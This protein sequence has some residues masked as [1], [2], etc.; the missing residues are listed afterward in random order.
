MKTFGKT[1]KLIAIISSAALLLCS[2]GEVST[3]GSA[4]ISQTNATTSNSIAT[5]TSA[6]STVQTSA[7]TENIG[8]IPSGFEPAAPNI[9]GG[10]EII[11][12]AL[13]MGKISVDGD[14]EERIMRAALVRRE[15]MLNDTMM[16]IDVLDDDGSVIASTMSGGYGFIAVSTAKNGGT[17]ILR[18]SF[19]ATGERFELRTFITEFSNI[20]TTNGTFNDKVSSLTHESMGMQGIG[21]EDGF[22]FYHDEITMFSNESAQLLERA[23]LGWDIVVLSDKQGSYAAMPGQGNT[24]TAETIAKIRGLDHAKVFAVMEEFL[25]DNK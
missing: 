4:G 2:C 3:T 23:G 5:S 20:N 1:K 24:V 18:Y 12:Q 16:Y 21:T 13:F 14:F 6:Q 7:T 22:P 15:G 17:S 25:K 10:Y 8:G 19:N 11:S 9:Y